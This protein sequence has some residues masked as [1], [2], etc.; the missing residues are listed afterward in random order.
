MARIV[1]TYDYTD[2]EAVLLYQNVR[3]EPKD[4]RQRRPDGK[5]QCV[6]NLHGQRR[7]D[8]V[9][10]SEAFKTI[11]SAPTRCFETGGAH[12]AD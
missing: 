5:R 1:S 10:V 9:Q 3:F 6:W 12:D 4:C 2:E 8:P 7:F 11:A